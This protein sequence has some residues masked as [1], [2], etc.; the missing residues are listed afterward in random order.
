MNNPISQQ[1]EFKRNVAYKLKIG[2]ILSGKP[3][4]EAEK[5]KFLEL[6]NKKIVRVNV[7]ANIID[8]FI[9]DEEKKYGSITI[10]DASGQMR[11]KVF[12]DDIEKFSQLNQG[13]TILIIGLVRLWNNELYITPEI[14]KKKEPSFLLVRKYEIEAE[15][16]KPLDKDKILALKDKIM[17]MIKDAEKDNG[18]DID[19]IILELKESPE[20]INQEIKKLLEEGLVYEPRPGRL[21]YLG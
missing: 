8:K 4:L 9:Q 5:L 7:I 2:D 16:P 19:R 3:V 11:V 1:P 12:G 10:D 13:D 20:L 17:S 18:V 6:E 15:I 21:R 14:I